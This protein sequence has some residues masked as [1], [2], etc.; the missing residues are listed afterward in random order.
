MY[1]IPKIKWYERNEL[2]AMTVPTVDEV[3]PPDVMPDDTTAQSTP[4]YPVVDPT[5]NDT[6]TVE[7][8]D[9]GDTIVEDMGGN[10]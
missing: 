7:I 1:D 3:T 10:L 8:I 6:E 5:D 4:N 9:N 2:N